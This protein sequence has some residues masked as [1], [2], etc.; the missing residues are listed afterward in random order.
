MGNDAPLAILSNHQPLLYDY[1]K[2][3]FAQ[4]SGRLSRLQFCTT[5]AFKVTNPPIDPFREK[6]VMSLACPVG[7]EGNLLEPGPELCQ[8]L[9]LDQPL[10]S[11][12]QLQWIK[13]SKWQGWRCAVLDISLP[14]TATNL[15]AELVRL[16]GEAERAAADHQFLVLSDRNIGPRRAALPA[17]LAVAAV[18]HHLISTRL[19]SKVTVNILLN[20]IKYLSD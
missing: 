14:A 17:L 18:H 5:S 7:P 9:W 1:F 16:C 2:Q 10:L 15:R 4:V 12:D 8:R 3:L 13:N 20:A 6:I 19:R 11:L